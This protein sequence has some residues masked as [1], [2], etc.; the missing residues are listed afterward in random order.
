MPSLVEY[1]STVD[2]PSTYEQ[3]IAALVEY[4]VLRWG[5]DERGPSRYLRSSSCKTIG[6]A[7]NALWAQAEIAGV[8]R[9][10]L[11]AVAR[12]SLTRADWKSLRQG[13]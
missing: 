13:G 6:L 2:V 9:P 7:I 8:R 11:E 12:A 5:E 3:A 1:L 4:D 10:D